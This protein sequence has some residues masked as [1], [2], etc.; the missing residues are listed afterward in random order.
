MEL[1]NLKA[2]WKNAGSDKKDQNELWMMTRIKNHPQVKKLR[3]KFLIES[4]LLTIF[5][6]VYYDGFDGNTKPLWANIVLVFSAVMYVVLR[7]VGWVVLRN[8]INGNDLK[9]SLSNFR[10]KLKGIAF[11]VISTSLLFGATIIIFFVSVINFTTQKYILLAIMVI[12]L[13]ISL[14]ISSKIW[15]KRV[16]YITKTINE[17]ISKGN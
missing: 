9:K 16:G 7:F 2:S 15:V 3:I 4:I 13:I 6:F 11:G 12:T 17:F 8:P 1:E 5:I 10:R 14:Y